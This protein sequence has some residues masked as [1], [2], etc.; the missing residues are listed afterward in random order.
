MPVCYTYP[1][2]L[3]VRYPRLLFAFINIHKLCGESVRLNCRTVP[4]SLCLRSARSVRFIDVR[5]SECG[6]SRPAGRSKTHLLR[7]I[8]LP[9]RPPPGLP[10]GISGSEQGRAGGGGAAGFCIQAT[11]ITAEL[12]DARLP[13]TLCPG[14][15]RLAPRQSGASVGSLDF[16]L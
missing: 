6:L 3:L 8:L 13:N 14:S 5:P 7:H 1:Q 15:H 11:L 4:G 9:R 16:C 12:R 2:C 10:V